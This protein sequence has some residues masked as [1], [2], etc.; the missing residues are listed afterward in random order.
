MPE[1]GFTSDLALSEQTQYSS[2]GQNA[3]H[4]YVGITKRE[5]EAFILTT[6]YSLKII[7]LLLY[8]NHITQPVLYELF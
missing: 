6:L 3:L 2:L 1:R 8:I 4:S 7:D 5:E